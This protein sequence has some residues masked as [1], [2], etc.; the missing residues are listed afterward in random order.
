[1]EALS[2]QNDLIYLDISGNKST[3]PLSNFKKMLLDKANHSHT[4]KRCCWTHLKLLNFNNCGNLIDDEILLVVSNS[5]PSLQILGIGC[6]PKIDGHSYTGIGLIAIATKCILL[7]SLNLSGFVMQLNVAL[8]LVKMLPLLE[9]IT[10]ANL[11]SERTQCD[12]CVL[13]A[14]M[15]F[16]SVHLISIT[17]EFTICGEQYKEPQNLTL[18]EVIKISSFAWNTSDGGKSLYPLLPQNDNIRNIKVYFTDTKR[19]DEKFML[20]L[21][22]TGG[23]LESLSL[24]NLKFGWLLERASVC[25]LLKSFTLQHSEVSDGNLIALLK[26]NPQLEQLSLVCCNV[27]N[28][29]ITDGVGLLKNLTSLKI[30]L[31]KITSTAIVVVLKNL[32][33]LR[34]FELCCNKVPPGMISIENAI[35]RLVYLEKVTWKEHGNK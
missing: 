22:S 32:V 16:E 33:R 2:K 5:C 31:S 10:I 7:K 14:G 30:V 34:E 11:P 15:V 29:A 13:F 26:C 12:V 21:K 24:C 18:D 4:S 20:Y 27:T 35:K 19:V 6:R 23:L 28:V 17:H 1:M 25:H 8:H 9:K 3:V